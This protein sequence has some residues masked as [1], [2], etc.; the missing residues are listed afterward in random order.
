MAGD[1]ATLN[2][3]FSPVPEP[4]SFAVLRSLAWRFFRQG[5]KVI[6]PPLL[7]I[8][9]V[10]TFMYAL[11]RV[12]DPV[13]AGNLSGDDVGLKRLFFSLTLLTLPTLVLFEMLR[14][15]P[16]Y[17][18]PLT[19]RKI[20]HLQLAFGALSVLVLHL[21]TVAYYRTVFGTAIPVAGPLLFLLPGILITA[22]LAALMVDARWWKVLVAIVAVGLLFRQMVMRFDDPSRH[23]GGQ[24][25]FTPTLA[26]MIAIL[27]LAAAGY[28]IA[29]GTAVRDRRGETRSWSVLEEYLYRFAAFLAGFRPL[30]RN[31]LKVTSPVSAQFAYEWLTKGIALPMFV[32]FFGLASLIGA[33]YEPKEWLEGFAESFPF[34]LMLAM[35]INGYC[36]GL[37]D[38]PGAQGDMDR[39]RA[40][41]PV[42]DWQLAG[43]ALANG[44]FSTLIASAVIAVLACIVYVYARFSGFA[45]ADLWNPLSSVAGNDARVLALMLSLGWCAMGFNLTCIATGR[46]GLVMAV[47]IGGVALLLTGL[48]AESQLPERLWIET[49]QVGTSA[50]AVL[51]IA[52]TAFGF[53]KAAVR[54]L[55]PRW[56]LPVALALGLCGTLLFYFAFQQ[57]FDAPVTMAVVSAGVGALAALPLASA[58]LA[59]AWNRHR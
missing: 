2:A 16:L 43:L 28:A 23:Q 26:E 17:T 9:A 39:Y 11:I 40:T 14:I 20:V 30:R 31:R 51:V 32:A 8:C 1:L 52:G 19:T 29:M 59:I 7:I 45:H 22:G 41:R 13:V 42:S 4:D 27:F 34:L 44:L 58:P 55:V 50:I 57:N 38:G 21:A 24:G 47:W 33:W 48:L 18:L 49:L 56:T 25:W 5:L 6:L 46:H 54:G 36:V 35:A 53:L 10:P 15:R 3:P 37:M 12:V